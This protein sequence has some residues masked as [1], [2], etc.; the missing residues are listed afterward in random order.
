KQSNDAT[1]TADATNTATPT[2]TG[3]QTQSGS[4]CGC[5]GPAVQAL[6]Q[7]SKVGQLG[8]ALSS[9]KQIGATNSD[10]PVR[11]WSPRSGGSVTQSN[12]A[13]STAD[14]TNTATPTQT[15]TQTQSGSSC[16]CSSG[17]TVQAIGQESKVGQFGVA[18]SS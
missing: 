6:G 9:A 12:D 4:S 7:E 16:G 18:L 17:P 11:V 13:T 8:A 5:S 1:S 15:G 14:A 3:T 2:Q 10:D